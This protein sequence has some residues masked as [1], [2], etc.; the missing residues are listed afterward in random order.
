MRKTK[1]ITALALAVAMFATLIAAFPAVAGAAQAIDVSTLGA[2][3]VSGGT[4]GTDS[5]AYDPNGSNGPNILTLHDTGPYTLTGTNANLRVWIDYTAT[6]AQLTLNG[7]SIT[8][9]MGYR[10]L[11]VLANSKVTLAGTNTLTCSAAFQF[12]IGT[13]VSC[14]INGTGTLVASSLDSYGLTNNGTLSITESAS[15]TTIGG[16]SFPV[17][18][19]PSSILIGDNASLTMT[20]NYNSAETHTFDMATD[21]TAAYQW[22]LS[23]AATLASGAVTDASISVTIPAGQTGTVSRE[24]IPPE[25]PTITSPD[26]LSVVTGTGGSMVLTATGDTPIAWSLTGAPAGVSVSG[27]TLSVASSVPAGTYTFT[28]TASN[29]VEPDATQ[30]FTLTV[31]KAG[32]GTENGGSSGSTTSTAKGPLALPLPPTGDAVSLLSP[33]M[34]GLGS[35]ASLSLAF[36]WRRRR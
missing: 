1:K 26:I 31:T 35:I 13:G 9:P 22:K 12:M 7:V 36:G 4:A 24:L 14:T 21:A 18:L 28:I 32:G 23:G 17:V 10:S 6:G 11:S 8:S 30:S 27:S 25:A 33:L 20:N 3:A 2:T 34:L 5:W 15:V 29:G 19:S 16:S